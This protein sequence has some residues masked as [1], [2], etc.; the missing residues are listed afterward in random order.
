MDII[1]LAAGKGSRFH[2]KTKINKC[3]IKINKKPLIKMLIDEVKKTNIENI[4]IIT[5]YRSEFLKKKLN[6]YKKINFIYNKYYNKKEMTHSFITGLKRTNTD[7]IISYTDI[8][9]NSLIINKI[10]KNKNENILIP[11]LKNWKR[12]WK[13]RGKKPSVDGE[14]I[15]IKNN[16]LIEIGKKI[17]NL[18]DIKY[19]Y[20]GI[21]FIPKSKIKKI[22]KI[23]DNLKNKNSIHLTTFLNL[24]LQKKITIK[25]LKFSKG[26]YEF[27]DYDD[28]QNYIKYLY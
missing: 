20:M 17:E 1:F 12:I 19:Q 28:Y 11:V 23:Y 7:L 6:N 18:K 4:N 9:F 10:I 16:R 3:L 24:L 26:W 25:T 21:I 27:D 2:N 15:Y 8:M 5:G 13:I 14:T 22:I